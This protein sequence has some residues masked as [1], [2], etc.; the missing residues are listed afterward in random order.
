MGDLDVIMLLVKCAQQ[1]LLN[2]FNK[3]LKTNQRPPMLRPLPHKG[4]GE[5]DTL[6]KVKS[7][8]RTGLARAAVL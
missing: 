3:T 4:E 8:H 5:T 6:V 1:V 2:P 7:L